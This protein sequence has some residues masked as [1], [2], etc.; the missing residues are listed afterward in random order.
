VT[1]T[2]WPLNIFTGYRCDELLPIQFWACYAFP[3]LSQ[4]EA[5]N[6]RTD[7]QTDTAHH[8]IMTRSVWRSGD[9]NE[10]YNK[11]P[12]TM[13]LL[14]QWCLNLPATVTVRRPAGGTSGPM[15]GK[16]ARC[17]ATD[18]Y[19]VNRLR[20]DSCWPT[21]DEL[22]RRMKRQE[23]WSTLSHFNSEWPWRLFTWMENLRQ[24]DGYV[25]FLVLLKPSW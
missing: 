3:F 7:G 17:K 4:I 9:N 14:R 21:I 10:L 11:I 13:D 2:F 22:Q 1:L 23:E 20:Y 6:R 19:N 24:K 12:S 25:H 15:G 8:F 16:L 5:C 18:S